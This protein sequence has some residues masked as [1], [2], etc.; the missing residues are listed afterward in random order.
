MKKVL[1]VLLVLIAI[2]AFA[3]CKQE[4]EEDLKQN[5]SQTSGGNQASAEDSKLPP[6]DSGVLIVS[7]GEGATFE[8][9]GKFQFKMAIDYNAGEPIEFLL[10][11][12][13]DITGVEVREGGN[14]DTFFIPKNTPISNWEKNSEGWYVISIP[15]DKVTPA[16]AASASLGITT[17]LPDTNRDKCFVAIKDMKINNEL[18][19]FT[20]YSENTGFIS[21]YSKSPDKLNVVINE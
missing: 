9:S 19:D 14:G 11:C 5:E 6:T 18:V 3:S 12:S 10:K 20:D 17:R 7:P 16:G 13:G 8:Q 21:A 2:F 4:P 15:A 1:L